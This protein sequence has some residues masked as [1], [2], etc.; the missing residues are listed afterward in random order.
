MGALPPLN[1][2][3]LVAVARLVADDPVNRRDPDAR[4]REPSHQAISECLT[5]TGLVSADAPKPAGKEKRVRAILNWALDHDAAA[6]RRFVSVLLATV[7]GSGGFRPE[8]P[9]FVGAE[10]VNNL[11]DVLHTDGWLLAANGDLHPVLLGDDLASPGVPE[12][13]HGYCRRAALG[14]TDDALVIG[15]SKDLVEAAAAY[16][17]VASYGSYDPRFK[18]EALLGQAFAAVG[19]ALPLQ[20]ETPDEPARR[21]LERGLFQAALA[22]NRLRNKAGTGHGRPF[23]PDVGPVEARLAVRTMGSVAELLLDA[24]KHPRS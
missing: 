4:P 6:G 8:S 13:L 11:R 2:A 15:T 21:K 14:S 5:R 20:P 10:A 22:V 12:A 16:V 17:L 18:F 7:K 1:D 23:L 24:L 9:N 3:V 19:L